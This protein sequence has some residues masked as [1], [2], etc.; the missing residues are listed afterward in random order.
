MLH[1]ITI[2]VFPKCF[3]KDWLSSW[4]CVVNLQSIFLF[5]SI[6][7]HVILNYVQL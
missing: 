1:N 5:D 2:T 7:K 4:V 6:D 3:V